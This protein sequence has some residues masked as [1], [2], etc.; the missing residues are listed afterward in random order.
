[1]VGSRLAESEVGEMRRWL[2]QGARVQCSSVRGELGFQLGMGFCL[3][4]RII[5]LVVC[6]PKVLGLA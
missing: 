3:R 5:G 1:M 2:W 6:R 4:P